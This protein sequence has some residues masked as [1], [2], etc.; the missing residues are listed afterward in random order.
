MPQ[1]NSLSW[2]GRLLD[3]GLRIASLIPFFK[4]RWFDTDKWGMCVTL[5]SVMALTSRRSRK[6]QC[7]RYITDHPRRR[8]VSVANQGVGQCTFMQPHTG[9]TFS[10]RDWS[11]TLSK[12][13]SWV[14][15]L[16]WS[17]KC[18][19]PMVFWSVRWNWNIS[20]RAKQTSPLGWKHF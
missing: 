9:W 2:P 10:P 17:T 14:F 3:A 20:T 6:A 1:Q 18:R 19:T 8:T 13:S 5:S 4:Q 11:T 15:V 12:H 16:A 7:E